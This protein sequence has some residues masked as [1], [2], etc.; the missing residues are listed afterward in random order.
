MQAV[1]MY[2]C[3]KPRTGAVSKQNNFRDGQPANYMQ[4]ALS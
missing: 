3:T 2:R 1:G 4:I